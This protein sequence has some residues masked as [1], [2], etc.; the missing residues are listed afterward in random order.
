MPYGSRLVGRTIVPHKAELDVLVRIRS[1]RD[2]GFSYWDIAEAL[3]T[4]GIKTK[5]S[6]GKWHART[7]L[8][9]LSNSAENGLKGIS[10]AKTNAGNHVREQEPCQA[11]FITQTT[12][13]K[14]SDLGI[15]SSE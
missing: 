10:M 11:K 5:T 6:K 3:N 12:A 7:V 14:I 2:K 4:L 9:V 1:L 8:G 13:V 15:K